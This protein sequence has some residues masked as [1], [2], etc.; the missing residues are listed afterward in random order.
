MPKWTLI[1]ESTGEVVS[2]SS[3]GNLTFPKNTGSVSITYIVKYEENSCVVTTAAT[4][5]SGEECKPQEC[6]FTVKTDVENAKYRFVNVATEQIITSGVV[7][8][9]QTVYSATYLDSG[10]TLTR[11]KVILTSDDRS[12]TFKNNGVGV[13]NCGEEIAINEKD[14]LRPKDA[15]LSID[16]CGVVTF[17][18]V[19]LV[20]KDGHVEYYYTNDF[21]IKHDFDY[22][23]I[24]PDGEKYVNI[25]V[26]S[27]ETE[28]EIPY[29]IEME[30]DRNGK[31][32]SGQTMQAAGPCSPPSIHIVTYLDKTGCAGHQ[33]CRCI[34]SILGVY[35]VTKGETTLTPNDCEIRADFQQQGEESQ[36]ITNREIFSSP[37]RVQLRDKCDEPDYEGEDVEG[38]EIDENSI[39]IKLIYD[40]KTYDNLP[41]GIAN[42]EL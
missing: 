14:K 34:D 19:T 4:V 36:T 23:L 25:D 37:Y 35:S 21:N 26:P 24:T 16:K 28:N 42:V 8:G 31:I 6:T 10:A 22:I 32:W 30:Y 33:K 40:G 18:S 13:I 9:S 5:M 7:S 12:V 1:N 27:N 29:T 39:I 41:L 2:Q 17:S 15:V 11:V 20:H 3:D 38:Y